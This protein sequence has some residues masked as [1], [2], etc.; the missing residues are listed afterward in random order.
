M[1]MQIIPRTYKI[2]RLLKENPCHT[3]LSCLTG[4]H[5]EESH[6]STLIPDEID[7]SLSDVQLH[8]SCT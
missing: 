2:R 1:K 8:V 5:I 3:V 4:V 6:F 7:G